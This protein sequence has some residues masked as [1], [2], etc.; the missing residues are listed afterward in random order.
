MLDVAYASKGSP[1]PSSDYWSAKS[2]VS[3]S[4]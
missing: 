3:K 2:G 4:I 1:P